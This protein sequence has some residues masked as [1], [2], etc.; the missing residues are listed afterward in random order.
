MPIDA[1]FPD[2]GTIGYIGD[3]EETRKRA[4]RGPA[5]CN[6]EGGPRVMPSLDDEPSCGRCGKPLR[7]FGRA[8]GRRIAA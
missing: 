1:S 5:K 4:E 2:S 6:C 8:V 7:A 3:P